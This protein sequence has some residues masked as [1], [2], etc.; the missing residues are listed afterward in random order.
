MIRVGPLMLVVLAF[1]GAAGRV[2][3]AATPVRPAPAAS[4]PNPGI[5]RVSI[6]A[7]AALAPIQPG[8][9]GVSMEYNTVSAYEGGGPGGG[10]PVLGQLIRKLAPAQAPIVRIGGDSA[11]WT[12]WPVDGMRQPFGISESLSSKWVA[13]ANELVASTGARLI[14][15]LN[16][17]TDSTVIAVT[18]AHQLL[19]GI[20]AQHIDALEI[21]NEPQLYPLLPWYHTAAGK[22][23]FGRPADYD[24]ADYTK[25]FDRYASVLPA[26]S[27]AG[28]SI[29]HSWVS[30]LAPFIT[31]AHRG[32]MVTFHAYAVDRYGAAFRGR[33]CS[34]ASPRDPARATVPALLDPFASL[35]LTR[36]LGPD[37]ALAHDHGLSF[38]VDEMNAVTCAGA[39]GVSDTFASALWALNAVFAMADAG[40]QGVNI[41]TWRGS[42]G[43][44]FGFSHGPAG[45]SATVRPEYYGLLMFS[46]AAPAGS[47]LLTTQQVNGGQV[48]AWATLT[49]DGTV[50]VVLI[51]EG[52]TQARSV[53]VGVSGRG[54]A[55]QVQRLQAPSAYSKTGVTL[56]CQSFDP[57]TTTGTIAGPA[58][59]S[60]V[61]A[62]A[63]SYAVSLPA[64]SAALLTIP[65]N[66]STAAPRSRVVRTRVKIGLARHRRALVRPKEETR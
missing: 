56:G 11:D 13:K 39:P 36:G 25:E 31:S 22:P 38:R 40:V 61:H 10:N 57:V 1:A 53:L 54:R 28:P 35:A 60:T 45:W 64:A 18:E 27:L 59:P 4:P 55:A 3:P 47:R 62:S 15:D 14:L 52:L 32:G 43:K 23:A 41:H 66:G 12:W 63:G 24:L 6:G 5:D 16:L 17:E 50:R 8:F 65:A 44:L 49:P 19:A 26:V 29:G 37:I 46:A 7:P 34:T 51:N 58:C 2:A 9:L 33:N 30:Q 42:A 48:Q 21:G 20:G